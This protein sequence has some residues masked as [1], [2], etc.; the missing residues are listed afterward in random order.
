MGEGGLLGRGCQPAA[1]DARCVLQV[2]A[3]LNCASTAVAA[4]LGRVVAVVVIA[5]EIVVVVVAI[6]FGAFMLS[7]NVFQDGFA[8]LMADDETVAAAGWH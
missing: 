8:A 6:K 4:L 1:G 5:V 2:E 7:T 3:V